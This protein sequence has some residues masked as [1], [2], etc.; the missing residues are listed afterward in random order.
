VYT[1]VDIVQDAALV[2]GVMVNDIRNLATPDSNPYN[3]ALNGATFDSYAHEFD[4]DRKTDQLMP[5]LSLEWEM[6]DTSMFYISYSEGFKSGGFNAVDSQMPAF[7]A[8]TGAPI[9]DE[10][11]LGFEYDDETAESIE[12]GGKH[13]LMDGAMTVNWAMFTSEYVDQQVSTFVGLGF[14]VA[15][16]ASSD[17]KGMEVD[18]QWQ[19][20]D[21]L[22]L[23][24]NL[25]IL[26]AEYGDFTAAG[27]T[28]QQDS[29]LL[30][31]GTLTSASPV[32]SA[33]GCSAQFNA[34]G[35]KSGQSQDLSGSE[36]G[37]GHSGSLTADYA[38]PLSN[39]LV[40]FASADYNFTDDFKMTGDHDPLDV[41]EAY[42]KVNLRFGIRAENWDF[43][44]Y[45]KN[46]TDKQ[47]AQGA[48]DIPLASGSH[49]RY[50]DQGEL[51]GGRFTYRF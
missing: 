16:A 18:M 33:M 43:L 36:F 45:G 30:G 50:Q 27:C 29:A 32:T 40:M 10:P 42:G 6:S 4:E 20:S 48:F 28:A 46:V 23:G 38:R 44:I 9:Y 8:A 17:V 14:V 2:D 47:T 34:A 3:A 25:A 37:A 1:K 12:F 7:D 22:R 26:D 24:A 35:A 11:G 41:Q 39:G 15:N 19:A 51:W 49:G 5:A 31:L 21:N 13:T